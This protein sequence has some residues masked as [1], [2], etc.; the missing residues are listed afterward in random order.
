MLSYFKRKL[1]PGVPYGT[2]YSA[3]DTRRWLSGPELTCRRREVRV[4]DQSLR[5]RRAAGVLPVYA[6]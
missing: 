2:A 3:Y 6:Q 1:Q 4:V 5:I